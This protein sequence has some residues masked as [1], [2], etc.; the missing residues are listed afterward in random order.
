MNK[1]IVISAI[2]LVAVIM[3]MS[4]IVPMIPKAYAAVLE[5]TCPPTFVLTA[6]ADLPSELRAQAVAIDERDGIADRF[7][8]IKIIDDPTSDDDR[9]IIVDNNLPIARRGA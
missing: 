2:A 5:G 3:G 7:V 6:I 8:C 4:A 1:T 9:T